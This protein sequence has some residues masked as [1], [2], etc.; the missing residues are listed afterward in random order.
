MQLDNYCVKS[1][2]LTTTSSIKDRLVAFKI[3]HAL[4]LKA[5]CSLLPASPC[6]SHRQCAIAE[7]TKRESE[8]STSSSV[9]V[10]QDGCSRWQQR[11]QHVVVKHQYSY[12]YGGS[13]RTLLNLT[14]FFVEFLIMHEM[15]P[16]KKE[17]LKKNDNDNALESLFK[18]ICSHDLFKMGSTT[19]SLPSLSLSLL[20]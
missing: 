2:K 7:S 20:E 17:L 19:G 15:E 6:H 14:S 8:C 4:A 12:S 10:L 16:F 11:L 1:G 3:R 13:Q 18:L 5:D 9:V